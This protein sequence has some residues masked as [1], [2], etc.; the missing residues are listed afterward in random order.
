V[1][2]ILPFFQ[3]LRVGN[4]FSTEKQ[5]NGKMS[6]YFLSMI[7]GCVLIFLKLIGLL[8]S[9]IPI[10]F[11]MDHIRVGKMILSSNVRSEAKIKRAAAFKLN[12]MVKNAMDV[13]SL[14][15]TFGDSRCGTNSTTSAANGSEFGKA[16]LHFAKLSDKTVSDGGWGWAWR[17]IWNGQIYDNEGIWLSTRIIAG[18]LSKLIICLIFPIFGYIF[19]N[20]DLYQ[21]YVQ[22]LDKSEQWRM[23][24]PATIGIIL[25]FFAATTLAL[26]LLPST[27]RTILQFRYGCIG[28]LNDKVFLDYRLAV[29]QQS[30]IFGSIFWGETYYTVVSVLPTLCD[31]KYMTTMI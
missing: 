13:H 26:T 11:L 30:L 31:L 28:S 25:G 18:N 8:D 29:E 14:T 15:D 9:L 19:L 7:G 1:F 22:Q 23:I 3:E 4:Y 21:T 24:V 16:L 12:R 6:L 17:S 5:N 27:I 10:Q 2:T 20:G